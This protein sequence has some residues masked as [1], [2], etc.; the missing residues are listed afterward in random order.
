[1]KR[2]ARRSY[3]IDLLVWSALAPYQRRRTDPPRIPKILRS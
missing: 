1:M 2:E 3:E